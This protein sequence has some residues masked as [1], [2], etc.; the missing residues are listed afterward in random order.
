MT[1]D[2]VSGPLKRY[3]GNVSAPALGDGGNI[4]NSPYPPIR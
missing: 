3:S 4:K 1:G 2:E